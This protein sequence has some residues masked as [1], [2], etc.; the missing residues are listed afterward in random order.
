MRKL[1]DEDADSFA[2]R[3]E[4]YYQKRP[5]LVSLVEEFYRSYR[6]L[7]ERYDQ[8]QGSF[9]II[10]PDVLAG[11]GISVD[12]SHT[13]PNSYIH[14]LKTSLSSRVI[15]KADN[16]SSSSSS[17]S[18]SDPE[19]PSPTKSSRGRSGNDHHPRHVRRGGSSSVG[20]G[21]QVENEGLSSREV[22]LSRRL[23]SNN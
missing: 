2:K 7:A 22:Y 4:M 23:W 6:A 8:Q 10:P 11:Y 15:H 5:E 3:A 17:D 18:D 9:Q 19:T 20:K 1:I 14:R 16:S 13:S 12:P 21:L